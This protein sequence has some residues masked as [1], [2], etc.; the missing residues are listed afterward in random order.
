M[1]TTIASSARCQR[2]ER[3]ARGVRVLDVGATLSVRLCVRCVS[4]LGDLLRDF[5]AEKR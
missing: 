3:V 2:C 5:M 4:D 1:T